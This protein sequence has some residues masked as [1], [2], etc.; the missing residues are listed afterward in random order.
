MIRLACSFILMTCLLL[1]TACGSQSGTTTN[2]AGGHWN[3]RLG[4]D[5]PQLDPQLPSSATTKNQFSNV[6]FQALYDDLVTLTGAKLT[7]YAAK[8]WSITPTSVT[9]ALRSDLQCVDGST[10][11]ASD[12]EASFKRLLT[13]DKPELPGLFGPGPYTVSS[14]NTAGTFTFTVGTPL[15]RSDLWVCRCCHRHPLPRRIH[16]QRPT[17]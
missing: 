9:F 8:S 10:L 16:H 5:W 13:S 12:V 7:G 6:V 1:L 2:V 14:D 11:K 4:G 17:Q 15:Q 3:V